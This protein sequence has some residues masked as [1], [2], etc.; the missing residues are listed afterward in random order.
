MCGPE[1]IINNVQVVKTLCSLD[2]LGG[3]TELIFSA[4][5]CFHLKLRQASACE[6][7]ALYSPGTTLPSS[8]SWNEGYTRPDMKSHRNTLKHL[9]N[10]AS[11]LVIPIF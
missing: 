3:G 2:V 7:H 6:L 11:C 10:V 9:M 8:K 4:T 5:L 1:Q